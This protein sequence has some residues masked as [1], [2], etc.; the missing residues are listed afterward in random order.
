M[1]IIRKFLNSFLF[2]S[3]IKKKNLAKG[4]VYAFHYGNRG[5]DNKER[6]SLHN[7]K[8][9]TFFNAILAYSMYGIKMLI[10]YCYV[11][12]K[13]HYSLFIVYVII[14]IDYCFHTG[15]STPCSS[16]QKKFTTCKV[17]IVGQGHVE[18]MAI[19]FIVNGLTLIT[20]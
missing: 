10:V 2:I 7:L 17:E 8:K 11:L 20:R 1:I 9:S 18:V 4:I 12:C 5:F 16:T 15:R 14:L 3:Q 13:G 19:I 6:L